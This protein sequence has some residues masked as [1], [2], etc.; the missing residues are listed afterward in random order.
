MLVGELDDVSLVMAS[1]LKAV[2][3][4]FWPFPVFATGIYVLL[5]LFGH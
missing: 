3:S 4:F 5:L 1:I 2:F